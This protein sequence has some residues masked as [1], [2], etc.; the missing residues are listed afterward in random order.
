[1]GRDTQ[2]AVN[3]K[4]IHSVAYSKNGE[5]AA[6]GNIDGVVQLYNMKEKK[7]VANFQSK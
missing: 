1:M 6:S 4:Y 7:H 3:Q 5:F 2:L